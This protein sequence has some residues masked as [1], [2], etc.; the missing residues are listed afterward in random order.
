VPILLTLEK[1]TS[2]ATVANLTQVL[3]HAVVSFGGL[4]EQVVG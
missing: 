2:S 3:L 1:V 4:N